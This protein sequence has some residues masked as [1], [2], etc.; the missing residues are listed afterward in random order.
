MYTVV[1]ATGNTGRSVTEALLAR[2]MDVQ[3]VGRS[4]KRLQTLVKQGAQ[5][6]VGSI[7]DAQAMTLAFSGAVGVYCMIPPRFD[8]ED[9]RG[10]QRKIG[11]SLA[12]ALHEAEVQYVVFL[13]SVG[14][15]NK[16]GAGA[17]SGLREVEDRLNKLEGVNVL[18]L[19]SG[20]LFENFLRNVD[21]IRQ[22]GVLGSP[23]KGD[24]PIPMIAARDIGAYAAE[25]LANLDFSEKATREL[26]GPRDVTLEEAARV[27]GGAIGKDDLSYVQFSY[28]DAEQA[29][30]DMGISE[31]SARVLVEMYRSFNDGLIVPEETRSAENT[32]PTCIEDFAQV[33]AGVYGERKAE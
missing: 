21:M 14:A 1:G 25:R 5:V 29:F 9:Y 23:V 22:M 18:S 11:E 16:D 12:A 3:A 2:G 6:L 30:L 19:R 32:T 28:E 4:Q 8:V 10:Y 15:Q 20:W 13:S 27:L 26:L 33:F 17:I 31:G 24:L 7:D